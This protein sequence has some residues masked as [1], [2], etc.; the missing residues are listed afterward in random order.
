M[1][2]ENAEDE[3]DLDYVSMEMGEPAFST[4]FVDSNEQHNKLLS[5]VGKLSVGLRELD[6]ILSPILHVSDTKK[7]L[8]PD[9]IVHNVLLFT[10][11]L[12]LMSWIISQVALGQTAL[13]VSIG[14]MISFQCVHLIFIIITSVKLT[15]QVLHKTASSSFLAQSYLSTIMLFAGIY[16][17]IFCLDTN[18]FKGIPTLAD[19]RPEKI[20][21]IHMIYFSTITMTS[22]GY[23]DV[24][25]SKWYTQ[26]IVVVQLLVAVLYNTAIFTSGVDHFYGFR[27]KN[28]NSVSSS[29][30]SSSLV[31]RDSAVVSGNVI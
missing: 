27:H 29:R 21:F 30:L 28:S 12:Q 14:V 9:W 20:L 13:D 18:A 5:A 7:R 6:E 24:I 23:G 22:T 25:P 10:V 8:L 4:Q 16:S 26:L 31:R 15:K 17:L 19:G 11:F 3:K 1:E 2:L